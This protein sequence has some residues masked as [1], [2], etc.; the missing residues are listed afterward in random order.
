MY[1]H[2]GKSVGKVNFYLTYHKNNRYIRA[3]ISTASVSAVSVVRSVPWPE[4]EFE[5]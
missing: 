1:E 3:S 2:F 4:K 5:N